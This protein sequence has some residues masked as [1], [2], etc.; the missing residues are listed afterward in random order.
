MKA[1]EDVLQELDDDAGSEHD[2]KKIQEEL[3][4]DANRK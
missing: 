1:V 3:G 4:N 2:P